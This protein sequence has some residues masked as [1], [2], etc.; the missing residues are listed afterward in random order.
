MLVLRYSF[1]KLCSK[2]NCCFQSSKRPGNSK[3]VKSKVA[4]IICVF[5][6]LFWKMHFSTPIGTQFLSNFKAIVLLQSRSLARFDCMSL[7][8]NFFICRPEGFFCR[9]FCVVVMVNSHFQKASFNSP[10][11][12]TWPFLSAKALLYVFLLFFQDQSQTGLARVFLLRFQFSWFAYYA[13]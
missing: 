6:L 12:E 4:S 2:G 5:F 9:N 8:P 3:N 13:Y 10:L 11:L 7:N 1:L